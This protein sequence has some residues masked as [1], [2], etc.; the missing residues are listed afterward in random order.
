MIEDFN[1]KA[2]GN[3][4]NFKGLKACLYNFGL[5]TKARGLQGCGPSGRPGSHITCSQECKEC[6]GMNPHNLK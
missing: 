4:D 2:Q 5:A 1:A 6:E 3:D